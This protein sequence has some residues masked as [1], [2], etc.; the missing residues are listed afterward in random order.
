MSF[1]AAWAVSISV[2]STTKSL[3]KLQC[4]RGPIQT[5][6]LLSCEAMCLLRA[7]GACTSLRGAETRKRLLLTLALNS[8]AFANK[9]KGAFNQVTRQTAKS[10]PSAFVLHIPASLLM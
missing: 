5:L 4:K 10:F 1:L 7:A 2:D 8:Q 3:A 6:G 9:L